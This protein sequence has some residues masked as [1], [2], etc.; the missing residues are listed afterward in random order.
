MLKDR[1]S[2]LTALRAQAIAASTNAA[3]NTLANSLADNSSAVLAPAPLSPS[4]PTEH[5]NGLHAPMDRLDNPP[6]LDEV[7]TSNPVSLL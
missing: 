5:V 1:L 6:K 7:L 2:T 3:V 4:P